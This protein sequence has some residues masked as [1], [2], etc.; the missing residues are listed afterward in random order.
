MYIPTHFAEDR[1]PVLHDAMRQAGLANL[2]TT[3]PDGIIASPLPLM[4]D[5]QAGPYGTLIGH[6]ARGNPQWRTT[7]PAIEALAIFMGPDAYISPSYYETKRQTGKVVPTWNYV[8][9]H[10]YGRITFSE[11]LSHLL[12]V[13]KRLTVRHEAGRA[14]PW[15]VEDAPAAFTQ[16]QL[17]GI[18]AFEMPITRLQGK[19]KQSQNR[20]LADRTGVIEG[21]RADGEA[22]AAAVVEARSQAAS[23][24]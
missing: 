10:A 19:W 6:M 9:I 24:L 3:G 11:D 15:A 14:E 18:V 13:V 4:L 22:A 20:P 5:P 16:S 12:D 17:K 23:D 21:L 2:V 1:L 8:T 7:D